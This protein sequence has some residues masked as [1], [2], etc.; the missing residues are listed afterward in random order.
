VLGGLPDLLFDHLLNQL[1]TRFHLLLMLSGQLLNSQLPSLLY[2]LQVLLAGGELLDRL[3]KAR[4]LVVQ[5]H[6]LVHF[7][8]S[9]L[10]HFRRTVITR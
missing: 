3:F 8:L 4:Y 1:L 9:G 2:L 5:S 7:Y 6:L 10:V